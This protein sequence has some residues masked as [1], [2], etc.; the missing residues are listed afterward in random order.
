MAFNGYFPAVFRHYS[1]TN[2]QSQAGTLADLF[3]SEERIEKM[4]D[5]II[6]YSRPVVCKRYFYGVV[7]SLGRYCQFSLAVRL[8][9]KVLGIDYDIDEYLL[10]FSN[11]PV[12][13][14]QRLIKP[15]D[16]RYVIH[17]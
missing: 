7:G 6:G 4:A 14:R 9:H 8:D 5:D 3:G 1:V 12:N 16:D 17:I 13:Q 11:I 15:G 2:T 10:Q